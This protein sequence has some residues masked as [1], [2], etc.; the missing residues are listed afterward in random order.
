MVHLTHHTPRSQRER[1]AHEKERA[2]LDKD[3]ALLERDKAALERERAALDGERA[4]LRREQAALEAQVGLSA[5]P[6]PHTPCCLRIYGLMHIHTYNMAFSTSC[7]VHSCQA[8]KPCPGWSAYAFHTRSAHVC[9]QARELREELGSAEGARAGAAAER[10]RAEQAAAAV[11]A[12]EEAVRSAEQ[13]VEAARAKVAGREAE[14]DAQ[15]SGA[16]PWL[17]FWLGAGCRDAYVHHCWWR[18]SLRRS[19]NGFK[20]IEVYLCMH[21]PG[22][23]LH[24]NS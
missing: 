23:F 13:E 1:L 17:T 9:P 2:L 24:T 19:P 8:C 4:E 18:Q 10:S 22:G 14:L 12:R 21:P 15:V 5:W 11:A 16:L 7:C 6:G 3:R 20:C